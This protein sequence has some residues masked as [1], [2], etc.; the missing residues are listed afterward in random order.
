MLVI[1][2][3]LNRLVHPVTALYSEFL[4]SRTRQML[5]SIPR[6]GELTRCAT[7]VVT[8]AR[9]RQPLI[10]LAATPSGLRPTLT[11]SLLVTPVY[12]S[13]TLHTEYSPIALD[14]LAQRPIITL[15][16]LSVP[17]R[18]AMSP[19]LIPCVVVIDRPRNLRHPLPR[20]GLTS[21]QLVLLPKLETLTFVPLVVVPIVLR[22]P[23]A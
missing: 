20:A 9:V 8:R 1:R 22:L 21:E 2:T 15:L 13:S 19:V 18:T 5:H 17:E 7:L 3:R 6:W 14:R 12:L 11:L 10:R 23:L 4:P 16:L